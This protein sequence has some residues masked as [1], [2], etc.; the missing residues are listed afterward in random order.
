[1]RTN[2]AVIG[3]KQQE[4][5]IAVG[6]LQILAIT[7]STA[8]ATKPSVTRKW[9]SPS[10]EMLITK[11]HETWCDCAFTNST[12]GL[13]RQSLSAAIA[14]HR[15]ATFTTRIIPFGGQ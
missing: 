9:W 2:S 13:W 1:L 8:S 10:V 3:Q 15:L 5:A 14:M 7:R 12:S 11:Q 6:V 4:N